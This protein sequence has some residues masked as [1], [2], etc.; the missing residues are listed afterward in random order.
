[1]TGGLKRKKDGKESKM[2]G[3]KELGKN[4][5]KGGGGKGG[6]GKTEVR[7]GANAISGGE[8]KQF[9]K[10]RGKKQRGK[11]SRISKK[12]GGAEIGVTHGGLQRSTPEE[13]RWKTNKKKQDGEGCG[14]RN[15]TQKNEAVGGGGEL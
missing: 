1:M 2:A 13:G 15:L 9:Q 10:S 11:T 5:K 14:R 8:A 6:E 7:G 12:K 4:S 3:A